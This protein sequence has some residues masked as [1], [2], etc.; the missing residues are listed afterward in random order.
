M[1]IGGIFVQTDKT[2]D[3]CFILPI[4]PHKIGNVRDF[5]DDVSEK[6]GEDTVDQFKGVGIRRILAFLQAMPEKGDYMVIFMQSADSLGQTLQEMFATDD[7]YSKYLAEQF[8][9]FT[10]IDL[11]KEEN[12]PKLE[13]LMDWR[14]ENLFGEQKKMLMMPWC[15]TVPLKQG[16]TEEALRFIEMGKSRMPDVEKM[17]RDHDIIR[18][19]SYLQSTPRGDFIVRHIL[20]SKPLDELV[21]DFVGCND[22]FCTMAREKAKELTGIDLSDPDHL[23]HVELLFKWDERHGFE[24]ADQIIAYTE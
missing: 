23:P 17:L 1:I 22:K 21:M 24:T 9:D 20:A 15:F 18:S 7:E 13:L 6:F 5:W 19:L 2:V 12:V 11:S 14:D 16:K 10:G 8:M 4:M 3:S